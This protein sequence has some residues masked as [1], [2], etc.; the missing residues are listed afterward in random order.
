MSVPSTTSDTW[1]VYVLADH[2][3]QKWHLTKTEEELIF[4]AEVN[5]MVRDSFR[6]ALWENCVGDQTEIDIWLLD[7]QSDKDSVIILA[8]AVNIPISPRVHYAMISLQT[9]TNQAPTSVKDF[10][11]LKITD[12]YR[13]SNP[14][15]SLTY[16]FLLCGINA[17][18]YNQKHIT[19]IK[20]QEEPDILEFNTPQDF[21]LAGSICINTPVFFSRN[22]GLVA[23]AGTDNDLSVNT[24]CPNTP[25]ETTFSDNI[26]VNNLS[27]YNMDPEDILNS[28]KDTIG[29]L[30]AA[31][32]FHIKNQEQAYREILDEFFPPD[33]SKLPGI[34]S[35]LDKVV[36][37]MCKDL[38]D[39]TPAGDP[40]WSKDH[41]V[42]L[43]SS[44]SMQVLHQLEDKQKAHSLFIKFL[45]E[46]GLWTQL[47]AST[48]RNTTTATTYILGEFAEKIVAAINLK[49]VANSEILEKA[50]E[51]STDKKPENGLTYQDLFFREISQV[52][53][54]IQELVNNCEEVSHSNKNPT[55]IAEIL[56]ETN[57]IILVSFEYFWGKLMIRFL[58]RMY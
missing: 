28:Y 6:S 19:V 27:I 40:R 35:L 56:H 58:F 57:D 36:V 13:E 53:K 41:Q 38:I 5:R 34:D 10:L 20:P 12:M 55:Q 50:I 32:I 48:I 47:S 39:D 24:T 17:Y 16:R 18:L 31:F 25:V 9:N 26:V 44:Y 11:L 45:K 49:N 22:H 7:I 29:Q 30:K 54:G 15:D 37:M 14:G 1:A 42:G 51:K 21:L 23:I 4:V 43:G 8:A 52:H 2:S 3:L 46:S 33:A